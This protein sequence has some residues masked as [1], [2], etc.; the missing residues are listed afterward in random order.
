MKITVDTKQDS[1]EEIQ[2]AIALL[3]KLIEAETEYYHR[4]EKKDNEE[5]ATNA[6]A[7]MFGVDDV[8]QSEEKK[9]KKDDEDNEVE[10]DPKVEMY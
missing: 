10:E 2:K 8:T 9:D 5:Q 3:S 7:G 4:H 6:F 1:K